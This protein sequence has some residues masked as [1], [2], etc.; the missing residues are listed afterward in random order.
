MCWVLGAGCCALCAGGRSEN[1]LLLQSLLSPDVL[2][3]HLVVYIRRQ[4]RAL[5]SSTISPFSPLLSARTPKHKP[6]TEARLKAPPS[7]F[8]RRGAV[9]SS[10]WRFGHYKILQSVWNS[11]SDARRSNLE[12]QVMLRSTGIA[13]F[14]IIPLRYP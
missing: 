10:G 2:I 4:R 13:C 5:R 12:K 6:K 11:S 3:L 7:V 14:L 1:G 9:V 8:S